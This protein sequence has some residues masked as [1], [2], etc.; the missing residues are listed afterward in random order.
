MLG[1]IWR[2][3][4]TLEGSCGMSL[5][6]IVKS[7]MVKLEVQWRGCEDEWMLVTLRRKWTAEIYARANV[8]CYFTSSLL[9]VNPR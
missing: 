8:L 7:R 6:V 1:V 5:S 2:M 4:I 3:T 9:V